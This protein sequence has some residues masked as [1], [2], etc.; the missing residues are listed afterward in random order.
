MSQ[1]DVK[2][3]ELLPLKRGEY[4]RGKLDEKNLD[5]MRGAM[6]G[7][8]WP[9]PAIRVRTLD[10]P[11]KVKGVEY[12]L[13]IFDGEH[14]RF[15]AAEF[16]RESIPAIVEKMSDTEAD[17]AAFDLNNTHG[18]LLDKKRRGRW[19]QHLIKTRKVKVPMLAKKLHL[20]ARSIYRML[21]DVE[22]LNRPAKSA[23]KRPK[24]D[25]PAAS[26]ASEEKAV[27]WTPEGFFLSLAAVTKEAR[28]HAD[29]VQTFY[30]A[31][32]DKLEAHVGPLLEILQ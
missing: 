23:A 11:R 4:I 29:A 1:R 21:K 18:A 10:K 7:R 12:K 15:I 8:D 26:A 25:K 9:F 3:T 17:I 16:K 32:K 28:K 2:L 20:T 24:K 14:R 13:A 22:G 5:R 19:V 6:T 30:R 27:T 31:H